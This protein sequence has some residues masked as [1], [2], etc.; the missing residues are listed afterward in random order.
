VVSR[1]SCSPVD[2]GVAERVDRGR[3]VVVDVDMQTR[4]RR[5]AGNAR[6]VARFVFVGRSLIDRAGLL[7]IAA[8]RTER[9]NTARVY[10]VVSDG[11]YRLLSVRDGD[12]PLSY[13]EQYE[14]FRGLGHSDE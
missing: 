8:W 3:V 9:A 11:P 7:L 6:G 4:R 13:R 10:L 5:P 2:S 12:I 1:G 14:G